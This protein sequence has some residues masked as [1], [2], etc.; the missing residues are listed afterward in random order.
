MNVS[1][2]LQRVGA[3][4]EA[5][6]RIEEALS[7][8]LRV[9]ILA[10]DPGVAAR[11]RAPT[12][13]G[14]VWVPA[15]ELAEEAILGCHA[16]IWLTAYPVALGHEERDVLGVLAPILPRLRA[17]VLADRGLLVRLSDDPDREAEDVAARVRAL[18][19][20]AWEVLDEG[21]IE[22]IAT[23]D[24]DR[25]QRTADVAV[26]L[27]GRARE[28]LVRAVGEEEAALAIIEQDISAITDE[29]RRA[30]EDGGRVASHT[31]AAMRRHGADL[32]VSLRTFLQSFE[33]DLVAQAST[34]PD[35]DALRRVLPHYIQHVVSTQIADRLAVWRASV[36]ADLAEVGVDASALGIELLLPMLPPS[37]LRGESDWAR[38]IALSAAVGGGI[39]LA[40]VGLWIPAAAVLVGGV[41]WS[42]FGRDARDIET[43]D[44][45]IASARAAVRQLTADAERVLS[46]QIAQVE[47][48]L[49]N[50]P[51]QRA[52]AI[53]AAT[54]EAATRL[55]DLRTY[56]RGRSHGLRDQ[57]ASVDAGLL[58]MGAVISPPLL[59]PAARAPQPAP[60]REKTKRR[61]VIGGTSP[62]PPD[63]DGE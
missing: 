14:V 24:A 45:L 6:Q 4:S 49:S 38:R 28:K 58:S 53:R 3:D 27:L 2:L 39:A 61:S 46:D 41:G 59:A 11:F 42:A 13:P 29:I 26:L 31:G 55:A 52:E 44:R 22:V 32:I 48:D 18:V 25:D 19:G 15:G 37:P 36:F 33:D 17:V 35:V 60:R 54:L 57:I 40:L 23:W 9:A 10:R 12:L 5:W 34:F 50:L 51:E 1:A 7:D 8:G 30:R 21:Q 20:S 56:H 43:R 62:I 63:E 16:A 47:E